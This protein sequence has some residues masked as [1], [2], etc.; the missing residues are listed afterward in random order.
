MGHVG[1]RNSGFN[2]SILK[3]RQIKQVVDQSQQHLA[4][5]RNTIK[6][7][8][9]RAVELRFAEKVGHANDAIERVAHLMAHRPDQ[10]ER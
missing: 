1:G 5:A 10:L 7:V 6:I 3:R 2:C 4:A 9:L 8:A